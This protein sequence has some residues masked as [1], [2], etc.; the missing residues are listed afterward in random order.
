MNTE[1][2]SRCFWADES[3]LMRIYHDTEWGIPTFDDRELFERL[4]LEGFQAGLSWRTILH[5]R[6]NF[7]AAFD[8]FDPEKI[9]VYD[10]AKIAA[11]LQDPGIVRNRLKVRGA[12]QNAHAYLQ[13]VA[14]AGSYSDWLWQFVGHQPIVPDRPRTLENIPSSTPEAEA[15]SKAL[16]KAGFIFV[17]PTICFA[18]MQS[19]GMIDDHLVGCFK[20]RGRSACLRCL[21][22]APHAVLDLSRN[23]Q[24]VSGSSQL[25]CQRR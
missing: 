12:V 22:T 2:T 10:E 3:D 11:L 5:K 4:L 16:K 1:S 24:R 25:S 14:H 17:G 20:Y 21:A 7:R 8:G 15:M 6:E 9:A 13:L 23:S 19:V 18:F